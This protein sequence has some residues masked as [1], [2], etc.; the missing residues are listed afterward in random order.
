[1]GWNVINWAAR[2]ICQIMGVGT[3]LS[4][5][6]ARFIEEVKTSNFLHKIIFSRASRLD[7]LPSLAGIGREGGYGLQDRSQSQPCNRIYIS[8]KT[9]SVVVPS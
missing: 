8:R 6:E 2:V 5:G 3:A 9:C 1:M 7:A 4:T